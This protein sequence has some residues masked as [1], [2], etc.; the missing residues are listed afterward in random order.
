MSQETSAEKTRILL[1]DDHPVIRH[2]L[3]QLLSHEADL[4]VCAEA[5]SVA[6]ALEAVESQRPDLAILD[7]SLGN[8]DGIQLVK[9]ISA[10]WPDVFLLVLSMHGEKLYAERAIRAGAHGYIMKQEPHE[11]LVAAIR[12]VA[13][14][15]VHLSD[16]LQKDWL[17]L[18]QTGEPRRTTPIESLTDRELAVFRLVGQGNSTREIADELHLSVKTVE[19]YKEKTK[20]KLGL[21]SATELVQKATLWLH[22]ESGD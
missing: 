14:G 8:E 3:R 21:R 18:I 15:G 10:R 4:D 1:V 19:T 16:T 17:R 6:E 22:L 7:I 20:E 11:Q 9:Q 2:G 12:R 5:G 13:S